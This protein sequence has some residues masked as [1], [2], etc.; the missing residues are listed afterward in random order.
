MNMSPGWFPAHLFRRRPS[1]DPARHFAVRVK[2][3]YA[4]PISRP[5]F[6][7]VM[8]NF[9]RQA[10]TLMRI[11]ALGQERAHGML[12]A[13]DCGVEALEILR[14][15]LERSAGIRQEFDEFVGPISFNDHGAHKIVEGTQ[16]ALNQADLSVREA[17]TKLESC[18]HSAARKPTTMSM[19]DH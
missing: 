8:G 19:P 16:C 5:A 13:G 10:V 3:R 1:I 7:S 18:R 15:D 17:L 6:A 2:G 12:N 9:N 4:R 14:V 11:A